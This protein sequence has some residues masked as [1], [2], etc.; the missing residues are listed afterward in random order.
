MR[1]KQLKKRI[2]D[3]ELNIK[4]A[5]YMS[6]ATQKPNPKL[7]LKLSNDW[8]FCYIFLQN[9]RNKYTLDEKDPL[10]TKLREIRKEMIFIK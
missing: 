9:L 4:G 2:L 10:Y 3:L 6:I 1:Y 5:I 7:K 8:L